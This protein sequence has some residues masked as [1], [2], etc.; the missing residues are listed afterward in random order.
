MKK[1]T[2]ATKSTTAKSKAVKTAK[3][4]KPTHS[5]LRGYRDLHEHLAELDKQGLLITVERPINKDTELHPLVRWQFRGVL[6]SPTAK[7]FCL[8]MWSMAKAKNTTFPLWWAHWQ[9]RVK[10]TASAWAVQLQTL[11]KLGAMPLPI[12]SNPSSSKKPLAK[13]LSFKA[14]TC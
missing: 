6:P 3:T 13:K 10:F 2:L 7:L 4:S 8:P 14:K 5:E 12:P 11:A 1:S 9:H